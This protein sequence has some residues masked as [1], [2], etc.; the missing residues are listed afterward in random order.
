MKLFAGSRRALLLVVFC[1]LALVACVCWV[2]LR[3]DPL[4]CPA[5]PRTAPVAQAVSEKTTGMPTK[6][7]LPFGD[8]TQ[9]ASERARPAS[10]AANAYRTAHMIK[11]HTHSDSSENVR[12]R[13]R[14]QDEED[15]GDAHTHA[16]DLW[17]CGS[18]DKDECQ[19]A[20]NVGQLE[21]PAVFHGYGALSYKMHN[22]IRQLCVH[23][24]ELPWALL[25]TDDDVTLQPQA[26]LPRWPGDARNLCDRVKRRL[27]GD[28]G[29][30][31]FVDNPT[32][33][34]GEYE[35]CLGYF[36]YLSPNATQ[37]LC[38]A[39]HLMRFYRPDDVSLSVWY[40]LTGVEFHDVTA[41]EIT[42]RKCKH[43]TSAENAYVE[44]VECTH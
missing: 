21:V 18:S 30:Q 9:T 40:E 14:M 16:H 35:F 38:G 17:L 41:S 25:Q 6:G 13:C 26:A 24:G 27:Q 23:Y 19:P 15:G 7:A 31:Y 5:P 37:Q 22:C 42:Y 43:F 34:S 10:A 28:A 36:V 29:S 32:L 20:R 11:T 44:S 3:A 1:N 8:D 39:L 12:V 2:H 33:T 4:R